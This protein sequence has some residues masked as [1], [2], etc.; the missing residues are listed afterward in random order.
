MYLYMMTIP[1]DQD[2]HARARNSR[3]ARTPLATDVGLKRV[4]RRL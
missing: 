3:M 2:R 1:R 4:E